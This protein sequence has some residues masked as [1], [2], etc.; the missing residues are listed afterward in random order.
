MELLGFFLY[1]ESKRKTPIR[2]GI[3]IPRSNDNVTKL[4]IHG[5]V[6]VGY[7]F[8]SYIFLI[9]MCRIDNLISI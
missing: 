8:V 3:N 7:L 1:I 4:F 2:N 9:C 5:S 6:F